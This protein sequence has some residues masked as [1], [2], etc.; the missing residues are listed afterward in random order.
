MLPLEQHLVIF[1]YLTLILMPA[2]EYVFLLYKKQVTNPIDQLEPPLRC[3]SADI[4]SVCEFPWQVW[5]EG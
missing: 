2:V 1:V 5:L 3:T 4:N